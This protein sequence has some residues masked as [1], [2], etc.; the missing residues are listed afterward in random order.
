VSAQVREGPYRGLDPYDEQDAA[1]F[2]GREHDTRVIAATL[3][4]SRVTVLHGASGVGKTSV[5]QAGVVYRLR[6]SA[7]DAAEPD[8]AVAVFRDW[9]QGGD[10][11]RAVLDRVYASISE[12]FDDVTPARPKELLSRR[13]SAG[14]SAFAF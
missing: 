12:L 13:S 2:V 3:R 6:R 5:L 11:A 8:F 1:F 9:S 10:P 14:R 4:S 7:R